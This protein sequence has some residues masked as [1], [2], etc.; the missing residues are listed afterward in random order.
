MHKLHKRVTTAQNDSKGSI[1]AR[2]NPYMV[3]NRG[4]MGK[5]EAY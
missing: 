3:A 4:A 5:Q 1:Y 2:E